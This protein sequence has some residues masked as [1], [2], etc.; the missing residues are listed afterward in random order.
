MTWSPRP[1]PAVEGGREPRPGRSFFSVLAYRANVPITPDKFIISNDGFFALNLFSPGLSAGLTLSEL[2]RL[3][4]PRPAPQRPGFH[5]RLADPFPREKNRD[6]GTSSPP[7][8][9]NI[10][11][12][13]R[14]NFFDWIRGT[15]EKLSRFPKIRFSPGGSDNWILHR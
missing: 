4:R 6:Y 13:N 8:I 7:E 9:S 2:P 15:N 5:F 14:F 3:S 1:F 11:I 10:K 12:K